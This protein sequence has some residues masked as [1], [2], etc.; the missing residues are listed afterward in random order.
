[1]VIIFAFG[2]ENANH[3]ASR[4]AY[5]KD[6][7]NINEK[8]SNKKISYF[9]HQKWSK[10]TWYRLNSFVNIQKDIKKKCNIEYAANLTS[11]TFYYV[12]LEYKKI[13]VIPFFYKGLGETFRSFFDEGLIKKL[14]KLVDN[15]NLVLVTSE[16]NERLLNFEN[17]A[18]PKKIDLNFY[19]EKLNEFLYI[20]YPKKC[21][22]I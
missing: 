7:K 19:N 21:D 10:N 1:M 11:N 3:G 8:Y 5:F 2:L 17:Y 22:D 14:Q 20:Y 16:N 15:N 13:Q 4:N 18:K 6:L 12:L 9:N